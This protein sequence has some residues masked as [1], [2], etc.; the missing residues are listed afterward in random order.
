[1]HTLF[2][3]P[4]SSC[5]WVNIIHISYH[6]VISLLLFGLLSVSLLLQIV[7]CWKTCLKIQYLCKYAKTHTHDRQSTINSK[8]CH[9]QQTRNNKKHRF[10]VLKKCIS[11][12]STHSQK[13]TTK[14]EF[15]L[16]FSLLLCN[17]SLNEESFV[18]CHSCFV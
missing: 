12:N 2:Y 17:R 7:S 15:V 5:F 18:V 14:R 9:G 16:S 1:M 13:L 8:S 4:S 3:D 10:C 6:V 11:S